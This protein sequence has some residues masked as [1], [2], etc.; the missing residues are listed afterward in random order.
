M[1]ILQFPSILIV[2]K[3]D[4]SE[5]VELGQFKAVKHGELKYIR[6]RFFVHGNISGNERVRLKVHLTNDFTV[7]YATSDWVNVSSFDTSDGS[8]DMLSWARFDFNRQPFNKNQSYYF[9]IE[10]GNYTR[11]A[12]TF[13]LSITYDYPAST[14]TDDL[15][16]SQVPLSMQVFTY[17]DKE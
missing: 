11:N 13:Y 15:D 8:H 9:S 7:A 10:S 5:L 1:A 3:L 12:N 4:T 17:Q 16:Y 6:T 2:K 14:Y